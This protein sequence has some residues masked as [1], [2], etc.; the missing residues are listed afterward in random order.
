MTD[1]LPVVAPE[2]LEGVVIENY[3]EYTANNSGGKWWLR[4][5]DWEA[6]QSAGWVVEW[7]THPIFI[8]VKAR[9]AKLY[10]V[11]LTEAAESFEKAL[12]LQSVYERGCECCGP[13]HEFASY[14]AADE[15]I[16]YLDSY[17]GR[18]EIES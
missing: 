4:T 7:D 2:V 3:V 11:S 1:N 6:L 14:T 13:P 5:E 12:P 18:G 15:L 8:D 17:E 16:D 10:G 9:S